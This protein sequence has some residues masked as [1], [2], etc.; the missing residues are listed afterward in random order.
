METVGNEE[1]L[2]R[3]SGETIWRMQVGVGSFLTMELGAERQSSTGLILG[4]FSL[5][6]YGAQWRIQCDGVVATSNDSRAIMESAARGLVGARV[7]SCSLDPSKLVLNLQINEGCSLIAM[8]GPDSDLEDWMLFSD[9]GTVLVAHNG[10]LAI[11]LAYAAE[12]S[13]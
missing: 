1:I 12:Q 6:I 2:K 10:R 3:I 5:W 9:D 8:P 13:D 11:E 4:Q 7:A